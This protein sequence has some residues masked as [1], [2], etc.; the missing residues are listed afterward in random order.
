MA[1][2]SAPTAAEARHAALPWVEKYRPRSVEDVS[3]QGEVVE[4]LRRSIE[5]KNVRR[6][7]PTA[8]RAVRAR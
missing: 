7:P 4:S 8:Q 1:A 6:P 2:S 3:H 5:S